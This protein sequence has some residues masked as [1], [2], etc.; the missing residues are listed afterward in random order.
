CPEGGDRFAQDGLPS[1]GFIKDH[2]ST[3]L[4]YANMFPDHENSAWIREFYADEAR[5][6]K[7]SDRAGGAAACQY[8]LATDAVFEGEPMVIPGVVVLPAPKYDFSPSESSTN[9]QGM[10]VQV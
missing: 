10:E 9:Y 2:S 7:V 8:A 1:D 4:I 3:L 5:S 6:A